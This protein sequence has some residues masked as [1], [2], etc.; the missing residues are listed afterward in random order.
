[1]NYYGNPLRKLQHVGNWNR[2]HGFREL[3]RK[4]LTSPRA[5]EKIE[6]RW[7][8]SSQIFD[9]YL[10]NT[11][12]S[13]KPE[14]TEVGPV[15]PEWLNASIGL[16]LEFADDA[17]NIVF[18]SNKGIEGVP[19]SGW[20]MAHRFGHSLRYGDRHRMNQKWE[21]IVK[22][23]EEHLDRI[24]GAYALPD[25]YPY[26]ISKYE[27]DSL[28]WGQSAQR[29]NKESAY[30]RYRKAV[31]EQLG[32]SR[33]AR[34][35]N[36]RNNYEWYYEIV[37]QFITTGR[38]YFLELDN[39]VDFGPAPFGRRIKRCLN[40]PPWTYELNA[41]SRNLAHRLQRMLGDLLESSVGKVFLM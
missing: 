26:Q 22:E 39:C 20:V 28:D 2:N 33:A 10:V 38:I 31:A 14:Y 15:D 40:E 25:R 13:N 19:M 32:S 18:T 27:Y 34:E 8:R 17:I 21:E 6:D 4:L 11:P 36:L 30:A 37:A 3:D 35:G 29:L 16:D 1:M 23:I 5:I 41:Y 12:K 24:I 7:R 9:I